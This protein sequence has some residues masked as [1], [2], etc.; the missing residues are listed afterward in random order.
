MHAV[1][2]KS[3]RIFVSP[4]NLG[5]DVRKGY[6]PSVLDTPSDTASGWKASELP[7]IGEAGTSVADSTPP[8]SLIRQPVSQAGTEKSS[9]IAQSGGK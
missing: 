8:I 3:G 6:T 2:T 7:K 4:D 5:E 1:V 9:K